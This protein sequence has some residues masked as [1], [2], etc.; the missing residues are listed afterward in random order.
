MAKMTLGSWP[1]LTLAAARSAAADVQLKRARGQDPIG[2]RARLR[3]AGRAAEAMSAANSFGRLAREFI[4]DYAKKKQRRWTETARL[5]G[6]RPPD[7]ELIRDGL[8]ERWAAKPV[9]E[10]A[11][12]DCLTILGETA[13]RA[14][15]GLVRRRST[16]TEGMSGAMFA[17]LS[18]FFGWCIGQQI[19]DR[20][21]MVG[22]K[23][24]AAPPSRSRILDDEEIVA[25]WSASGLIG[26]PF[27]P[28]L[29]LLLLTGQRLREISELAFSEISA[30]GM[31][32][33]LAAGR[34]KNHRAHFVPLAPM[35][36]GCSPRIPFSKKDAPTSS[37]PAAALPSAAGRRSSGGWTRSW[38]RRWTTQLS[39]G[40]CTI[41]GGHL[42]LPWRGSGSTS[43]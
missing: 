16:V 2:E 43:W 34:T 20:S 26:Q 15:P 12:R 25:F 21:P 10:I 33:S 29:R 42:H 4:E 11:G 36:R 19:I 40:A 41:S 28:A 5:L 6:L 39:P 31:T 37:A 13:R 22:L 32:L 7:L 18:R 8:A 1:A 35:A 30:D 14:P 38:R 3:D 17:V 24:P 9:G 27:G 23:R